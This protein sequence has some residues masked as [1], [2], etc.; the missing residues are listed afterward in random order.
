MFSQPAPLVPVKEI[1][2]QPDE[3]PQR[4]AEPCDPGQ[5]HHQ[6]AAREDAQHRHEGNQWRSECPAP[7]GVALSQDQDADADE[8]ERE[9]SADIREVHHLIDAREHRRHA[10]GEAGENRRHRRDP[11]ARMHL[12]TPQVTT[13]LT[14]LAVGVTAMFTSIDEMVD[15]TNIG[16]L[17]AFILVCIGILILR[18]RD[19]G[20]R[21][22]FKTPLVPLVPVLGVLSCGYLMMGLPWITWLRFA[23]WLLV[24]L[25]I[26]FF[27]GYERSGLREHL[28]V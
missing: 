3:E 26:Y 22:A 8:N 4:E 20:R 17:F 13:I 7:S 18:R 23:L 15:L 28:Q 24:G 6:I 9:Q 27:Y 11:K 14:G 25:V 1:N 16:T 10:N 2:H 5:S 19:P 21:R 12:R